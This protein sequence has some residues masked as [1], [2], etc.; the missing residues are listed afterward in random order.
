MTLILQLHHVHS[1]SPNT[2]TARSY[3]SE[4]ICPTMDF[5]FDGR[6][7]HLPIELIIYICSFLENAS[8]ACAARLVN[9]TFC[10]AATPMITDIW[11]SPSLL[12]TKAP[13][14]SDTLAYNGSGIDPNNRSRWVEQPVTIWTWLSIPSSVTL[15]DEES[16]AG[17]RFA[18][19]LCAPDKTW[20]DYKHL[21]FHRYGRKA[22]SWGRGQE[23][24]NLF[25]VV[26][27]ELLVCSH[28]RI[29]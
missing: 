1:L 26:I 6:Q 8:D 25:C 9:R 3:S 27:R 24:P 5:N 18:E 21:S 4:L 29:I 17:K 23:R 11:H 22:V 13:L 28:S 10:T 20:N 15:E 16:S 12:F 7:L 2:N 14:F 19:L